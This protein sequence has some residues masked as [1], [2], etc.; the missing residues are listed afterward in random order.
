[1]RLVYFEDFF[2]KVGYYSN[3][4]WQRVFTLSI[5]DDESRDGNLSANEGHDTLSKFSSENLSL[6]LRGKQDL[7]KQEEMVFAVVE[8]RH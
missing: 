3:I 7:S 5:V 4:R 1:M 2:A 6:S 8:A